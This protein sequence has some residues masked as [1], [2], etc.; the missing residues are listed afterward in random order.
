MQLIVDGMTCDHCVRT[1]TQS[2]RAIDPQARVEVDVARGTVIIAGG[3]DAA[4]A[5]AAIEAEGYR[6]AATTEAAACCGGCA[7]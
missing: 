4:Q 7:A 3:V 6:V 5:T 2:I 1:I